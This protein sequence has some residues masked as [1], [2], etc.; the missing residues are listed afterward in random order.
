MKLGEGDVLVD[1]LGTGL[2]L[3]SQGED[4]VR[5]AANL[6]KMNIYISCSF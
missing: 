4:G 3:H 5:S 6:F 2:G 1:S